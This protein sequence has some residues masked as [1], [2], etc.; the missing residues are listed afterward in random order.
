VPASSR[1]AIY[2]ALFSK[3]QAVQGFKT[4]SR[5]AKHWSQVN[6]AQQP[7]VFQLQK[8]ESAHVTRGL[9]TRWN[10]KL[11]L[12]V[13][14]TQPNETDSPAITL[15]PLIDA[16]ETALKPDA[17]TGECTLGN[18]VSHCR[19]EGQI[20]IYEGVNEGRQTVAIIPIDI[21]TA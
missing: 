20:E 6:K 16:I 7:A 12:F 17:A 11:D 3:L 8:T 5:R 9:P 4:V 15:N 1:E 21:M 13:Y 10:M 2:S 19:I 14:V 18:L